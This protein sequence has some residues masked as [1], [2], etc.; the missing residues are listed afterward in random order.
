M[1]VGAYKVFVYQMPSGSLVRTYGNLPKSSYGPW[2]ALDGS[3]KSLTFSNGDLTIINVESGA[4]SARFKGHLSPDTAAA[5]SPDGSTLALGKYGGKVEIRDLATRAV[6]A[7]LKGA[8]SARSLAISPDGTLL[9]GVFFYNIDD[10]ISKVQ[11]WDL[12]TGKLL[13]TINDNDMTIGD[14]QFSP[15]GSS[16][17]MGY[18]NG[19]ITRI[20]ARTGQVLNTYKDLE[21]KKAGIAM[22]QDGNT[23]ALVTQETLTLWDL[24]AGSAIKEFPIDAKD[25][26]PF[27]PPSTIAFSADGSLLAIG[28]SQDYDSAMV[29]LW[30]AQTGQLV[31]K[32]NDGLDHGAFAGAITLAFSRDNSQLVA[33]LYDGTILLIDARSGQLSRVLH[34]HGDQV[35]WM[36]F[37]PQNNKL[38]SASMDGS[39]VFW[40]VP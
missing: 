4:E 30:N 7:N 1:V 29:G 9:T 16:V 32:V 24:A 21:N 34:G 38:V 23:V 28:D 6:K 13:Y 20:D 40:N 26:A 35:T 2:Y 22:A 31:G 5:L 18:G 10:I 8:Y 15:D 3:L 27:F 25:I 17:L 37:L 19:R 36:G 33:G 11:T 14:V 12:T 39:V